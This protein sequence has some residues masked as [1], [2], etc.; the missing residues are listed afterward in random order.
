MLKFGCSGGGAGVWTI[1]DAGVVAVLEAEIVWAGGW[2]EL[3]VRLC[4]AGVRGKLE[5]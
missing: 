4:Y 5:V 3:E 2:T 1:L